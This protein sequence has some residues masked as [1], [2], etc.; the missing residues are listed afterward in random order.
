MSRIMKILT[1]LATSVAILAATASGQPK[2]PFQDPA[3]DTER[4]IDNALWC[5]LL[6]VLPGI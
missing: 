2:Y 6:D 3:V 4:R 5:R 1:T